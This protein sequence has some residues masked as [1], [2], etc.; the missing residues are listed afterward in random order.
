[1]YLFLFDFEEFPQ[2]KVY[3]HP[4]TP[5]SGIFPNRNL[6]AS[7]QGLCS[8]NDNPPKMRSSLPDVPVEIKHCFLG[9]LQLCLL[10]RL[11]WP[12]RILGALSMR[13]L[14]SPAPVL[15][16]QQTISIIRSGI[17]SDGMLPS[18]SSQVSPRN[19]E[20]PSQTCHQY[21]SWKSRL[22]YRVVSKSSARPSDP[23]WPGSRY[24]SPILHLGPFICHFSILV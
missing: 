5:D 7:P 17:H 10:T 4:S 2:L 12:H 9:R 20:L 14:L 22:L 16:Y 21:W 6:P 24:N 15:Q 19:E 3:P 1:M 18:Y 8:A 11:E 13:W 23:L